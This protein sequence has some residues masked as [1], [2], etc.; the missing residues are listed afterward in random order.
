MP[1][2]AKPP[3]GATDRVGNG[4]G[5]PSAREPACVGVGDTGFERVAV[6]RPRQDVEFQDV[7]ELREQER[8]VRA[9]AGCDGTG[10]VGRLETNRELGSPESA[11]LQYPGT[12]R[13]EI[14]S[15]LRGRSHRPRKRR[16]AALVE[17]AE[18]LDGDR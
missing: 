8:V 16:R 12:M 1:M 3:V 10:D 4:S 11:W 14:D 17:H 7:R 18:G 15:E 6:L 2:I 9:C 5:E 13:R